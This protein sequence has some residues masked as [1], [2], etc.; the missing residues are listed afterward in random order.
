MLDVNFYV[1]NVQERILLAK[2]ETF[3]LV[4]TV[5]NLKIMIL[6]RVMMWA[7]IAQSV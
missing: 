7:G 1:M 4:D 3:V 5:F 2:R 6:H